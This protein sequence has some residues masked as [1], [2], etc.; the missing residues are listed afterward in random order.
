M[1]NLLFLPGASGSREFWAPVRE[2]LTDFG[3]SRVVAWPGLGGAPANP[4]VTRFDD[5]I[6]LVMAVLEPNTHVIAQSM[7]TVVA[8]R[9]ALRCQQGADARLSSLALVATAGGL[10]MQRLGATD[11]RE[12]APEWHPKDAPRYFFDERT[13]FSQQIRT[14][15]CPTLLLSGGKDPL[16]P[17]SVSEHLQQLLPNARHVS[18]DRG[19]HDMAFAHPDWVATQLRVHLSRLPISL[20]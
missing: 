7:G 6:E 15:T 3:P 2:R 17:P 5:L 14:I 1:M 12:G 10:D 4:D 20:D 18:L 11:W 16:S 8:L 19:E 9:T 13:D